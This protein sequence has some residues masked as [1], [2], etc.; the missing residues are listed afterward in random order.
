MVGE[1]VEE[2]DRYLTSRAA[3]KAVTEAKTWV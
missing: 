1:S 3:A 2:A